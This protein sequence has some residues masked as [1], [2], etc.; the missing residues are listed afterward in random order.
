MSFFVDYGSG[1]ESAGTAATVRVN[2]LQSV[3]EEPVY[4]AVRTTFTPKFRQFCQDPQIVRLRAILSW[5]QEPTGASYV[6]VY[7][8]V[9]EAYIQIKPKAAWTL[10]PV[11][12]IEPPVLNSIAELFQPSPIQ[13]EGPL[14]DISAFVQTS[15][16]YQEPDGVEESRFNQL[17]L[18][19]AN[20]NYFGSYSQA[21]D[22]IQIQ[23]D[24]LQLP[25]DFYKLFQELNPD[26]LIPVLPDNPKTKYEELVCVGLYPEADLLEAIIHIKEEGGY[27][28]NLCGNGSK[29]YVSFYIDFGDGHGYLCQGTA[30]LS[31]FN[32]PRPN[33][34]D[35]LAYAVQ[36]KVPGLAK[37]LK[38]CEIENVVSVK[39]I[40]SWNVSPACSGPNFIPAWGNS[41]ERK[42]ILRP[43]TGVLIRPRIEVISGVNVA[44]IQQDA[45]IIPDQ[46]L[47]PGHAVKP[48]TTSQYDRPFGKLVEFRGFVGNPNATHYKFMLKPYGAP[49]S[50]YA[51]LAKPFYFV[52]TG[53]SQSK[54]SPQSGTWFNIGAYKTHISQPEG[55]KSALLHWQ[56]DQPNGTYTF[57]LQLGQMAGGG[58]I[59]P[60]MDQ[61]TEIHLTLNEDRVEYHEFFGS[62]ASSPFE[63]ITVKDQAGNYKACGKFGSPKTIQIWGNFSH[64]YYRDLSLRMAGGNLPV[65]GSLLG[66]G[67]EAYDSSASSASWEGTQPQGDGTKGMKLT[68]INPC[69]MDPKPGTEHIEC[70]YSIEM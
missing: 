69:D 64:P 13:I 27:T 25:Q 42:V 33:N 20:P 59:T 31:V 60:L 43:S 47:G 5:N 4:Y 52:V 46:R 48:G 7:G 11:L 70:A 36:L 22:P 38:R 63:G 45:I 58:A 32:I 6:P 9:E 35:P 50:E 19:Q 40:L 12:Q 39:A 24:L 28:T 53:S 14:A 29:E 68:S 65:G 51:D 2:D 62:P 41:L 56:N 49:D 21:Q 54:T 16:E 30:A 1:W 67:L 18:L 55:Y 23:Q 61:E 44:N 10:P 3:I 66:S 37:R 15:L 8:E 26:I 17:S 57:K 34:Q